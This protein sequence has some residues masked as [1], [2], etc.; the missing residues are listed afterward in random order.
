MKGR[1]AGC[2]C[3]LVLFALGCLW[4]GVQGFMEAAQNREPTVVAFADLVKARPEKTWLRIT[5]AQASVPEAIYRESFGSVQEAFLPITATGETEAKEIRLLVA[6]KDPATLALVGE[7]A[8]LEGKSDGEKLSFLVKNH[9]RLVVKHDFEGTIRW[10]IDQDSKLES[11]IVSAEKRLVT[12]FM[13]LDEGKAPSVV[14]SA[15]VSA[16]GLGILLVAVLVAYGASKG[17]APAETRAPVPAAIP[18]GIPMARPIAPPPPPA[19]P[20]T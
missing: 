13:I 15:M 8:S 14:A 20:A 10:G 2:G 18:M 9:E 16:V 17:G 1:L 4:R 6:V 12:D 11:K 5:G 3:L 19:D 7:I